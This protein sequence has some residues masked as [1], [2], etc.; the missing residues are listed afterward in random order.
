[1]DC[2]RAE[3]LAA[4]APW[5]G[6]RCFL[7]HISRFGSLQAWLTL[8]S[9]GEDSLLMFS[10]SN[11]EDC[12]ELHLGPAKHFE[13]GDSRISDESVR[14][15]VENKFD[16]ILLARIDEELVVTIMLPKEGINGGDE[17]TFVGR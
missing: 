9:I 13:F 7:I 8:D 6:R 10:G 1:M 3:F 4:L 11:A 5:C 12:L 16:Q 15:S 14:H 2:S 17:P